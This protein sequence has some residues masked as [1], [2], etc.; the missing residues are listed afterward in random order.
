MLRKYIIEAVQPIKKASLLKQMANKK[1]KLQQFLFFSIERA[2]IA[3]NFVFL[4]ENAIDKAERE[5]LESLAL[6]L[7]RNLSDENGEDISGNCDL[8]QSHSIWRLNYLSALGFTA[9][10]LAS[11]P[12]LQATR[13]HLDVMTSFEE[14]SIFTIAGAILVLE[15]I[16]PLEYSSVKRSRDFLFPELFVKSDKD[17]PQETIVK[18]QNARY[19]DDHI[20][21]D[22]Q[23]HY[24]DL[25]KA[26]S[27][28]ESNKAAMEKITSSIKKVCMARLEFYRGIEAKW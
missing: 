2:R 6:S 22:S 23:K 18:E 12:M 14:R 21:H 3:N 26:L 27:A 16:I 13:Q 8:T 10:S 7:R 28:F 5:S 4:L 9:E 17:S 1:V 20:V 24:P 11:P 19:I 15:L 25:L